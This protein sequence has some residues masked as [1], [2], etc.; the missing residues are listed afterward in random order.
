MGS[1]GGKDRSDGSSGKTASEW[2]ECHFSGQE[3]RLGLEARIAVI[4][5]AF[6]GC[7][8]P[9]YA[10]ASKGYQLSSEL[11]D[12]ECKTLL[13]KMESDVVVLYNLPLAIP[14]FYYTPRDFSLRGPRICI[15]VSTVG[16]SYAGGLWYWSTIARG[17]AHQRYLLKIRIY[18]PHTRHVESEFPEKGSESLLFKQRPQVIHREVWETARDYFLF[19]VFLQCT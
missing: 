7:L 16:N 5:A 10:S 13:S 12:S 6:E 2:A 14:S 3:R 15:L 18:G 17:N 4:R 8:L 1:Q 9:T 11:P 19:S